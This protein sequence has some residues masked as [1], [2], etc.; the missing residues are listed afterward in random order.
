MSRVPTVHAALPVSKPAVSREQPE[1]AAEIHLLVT[2]GR[3]NDARERYG[4]LVAQHQRR[5][6]RLAYY[7]L[8]D[9]AEA[10][11][12]VQ[13]AFVKAFAHIVSYREAWPFEVW[14]TRI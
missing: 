2:G 7:Y 1:L 4:D 10:D 6:S 13:D 11:E 5:A 8:R 9:A 3:W 12:A 14:F